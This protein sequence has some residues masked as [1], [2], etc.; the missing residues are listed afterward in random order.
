M[1]DDNLAVLPRAFWLSAGALL[2]WSSIPAGMYFLA[3]GY[4]GFPTFYLLLLGLAALA[5]IIDGRVIRKFERRPITRKSYIIFG[6]VL[7]VAA[8]LLQIYDAVTSRPLA[9]TGYIFWRVYAAGVGIW[10]FLSWLP[11]FFRE[12]FDMSL[13]AAGFAGTFM[14]QV[15]TV[16]GIA[17]GGWVSDRAAVRGMR[18]RML[19]QGLSY[20]A[21]APFLLLFLVRPAFAVVAVAV[22]F[23]SL[24][25]GLGQANEN[26]ILCEVVPAQLRSTAIGLMN[27]CATAAGGV[28][29]L[30]AGVLKRTL[31]LDAVFAGISLLFVLAGAALLVAHRWWMPRDIACAAAYG[32]AEN[33]PLPAAN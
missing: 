21:A 25:R 8:A 12:T 33:P 2:V 14:L 31:G 30:L 20:L 15:S 23:F 29:V 24:F 11:L 26:P 6:V 10:V 18:H 13:G 7:W 27:T 28:G 5:V 1:R 19:V 3:V 32:K 17:A 9:G 22:S 16:I 4:L